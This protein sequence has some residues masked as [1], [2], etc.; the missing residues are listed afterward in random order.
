[1]RIPTPILRSAVLA[2]LAVALVGPRTAHTADVDHVF[3]FCIDGVRASEGFGAPG[4]GHLQALLDGLAPEGSLLTFVEN[5]AL[6]TTLPAHQVV[7]TGD[8]SDY[9]TM[10]P[11]E[12]RLY[13]NPRSPTLFEAFRHQ[14]GAPADSCWV[15]SNTPHLYDTHRSLMP[16][17][18]EPYEAQ[19]RVSLSGGDGDPWVWDQ[20]DEVMA[21]QVVSLMLVNL[22]ETDRKAHSGEWGAYTGAMEHASADLVSFWD[23]LQADPDYAGRTALVVFTDHG[24]HLDGVAEGWI[25]HGDECQG[26]RQTFVLAL[27]PGIRHDLV[28][29]STASLVD[30]APTVAHLMGLDLPHARGRVLTGIL[31]D[32]TDPGPGGDGSLGLLASGDL[33]IRSVERFDP[34]LDDGA[35]AHAV[36]VEGSDD[37]GETWSDLG[38]PAGDRLQHAPALWSDGSVALVGALEF[39]PRD[40]PWETVLY[41]RSPETGAWETVL[42]GEMAGSSTPRGGLA[43]LR[44]GE[45][46]LLLENNPRERRIRAWTS[47]D[48]GRTWFEDAAR[49]YTYDTRR[50]PR[51][52][53][54]LRADDGS[55]LVLF[56]ANVAYQSDTFGPHDNTEVYRLRSIDDG[57]TWGLDLAI[58]DDEQPSIQPRGALDAEGTIHLVWAD[59]ASGAFQIHHAASADHGE[60]W[61]PAAALTDAAP[62]AWE[63]A[64]INDGVRPWLAWAQVEEV[65]QVSIRLAAIQDGTLVDERVLR[66][67]TGPARSPALA[68]AE[69]G[70]LLACWA[71]AP[72]GGGWETACSREIVAWYPA[73]AATGSVDPTEVEAGGPLVRA[74]FLVDVEMGETSAGFDRLSVRVPSP[75]EP[76][77]EVQLLVDGEEPASASWN[78][79]STLWLQLAEP[80]TAPVSLR[81]EAA[82]FPP[83]EGTDPL[84]FAVGLHNGD[85]PYATEVTGDLEIA[86]VEVAGDCGC[87]IS[88]GPRAPAAV[89]L[90]LAALRIRRR[91]R[92]PFSGGTHRTRGSRVPP[93]ERGDPRCSAGCCRSTVR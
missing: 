69:P 8:Y 79:D 66:T 31:E 3:I 87:R 26:C 13:L 40:E 84:A 28:S 57:V 17:Y 36:V 73:L 12:D 39:V 16:G 21:D 14:T 80:I 68:L 81:I 19:R 46:L 54:A 77:A 37:G 51:D 6:T 18:G 70:T 85:D 64:L 48:L 25:E 22:H 88:G 5:R 50:F 47:E 42:D 86:A 29:D 52:L 71:E 67:A 89:L 20:I 35:G 49:G 59:W 55:L 60:S 90:L 65:D 34:A 10:P 24:R 38:L 43:V 30:V 45:G 61:T 91:S 41:R 53:S 75:F 83:P 74:T 62:G 2:G 56:S 44:L 23:Q 58:S 72:D 82:L 76:A 15:V 93:G 78:T 1:M 33:L 63:P 4:G 11:N 32:A 27:G 92:L 9:D 7:V